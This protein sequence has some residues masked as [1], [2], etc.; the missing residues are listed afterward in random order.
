MCI[1]YYYFVAKW[2]FDS[3]FTWVFGTA[4]VGVIIHLIS[5]S[6]GDLRSSFDDFC[7][8]DSLHAVVYNT[9]QAGGW[10]Y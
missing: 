5:K 6:P 8:N 4:F 7:D 2:L 3:V 1:L 9:L 10:D